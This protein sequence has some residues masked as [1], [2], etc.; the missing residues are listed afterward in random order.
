MTCQMA[1]EMISQ[2]KNLQSQIEIQR[3]ESEVN[4]RLLIEK[5]LQT[6]S[7]AQ[8]DSFMSTSSSSSSMT[9]SNVVQIEFSDQIY[10]YQDLPNPHKSKTFRH[11]EKIFSTNFF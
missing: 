1:Q 10:F 3:K 5:L 6:S 9:H 8:P 2:A 11:K 4:R 7:S